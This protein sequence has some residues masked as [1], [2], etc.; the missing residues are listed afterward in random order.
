MRNGHAADVLIVSLGSTEGLRRAD[1]E[2]RDSLRRAGASVAL[3]RTHAPARLPTLM[4]TDLA[5]ARA[6]RAS[7]VR[8]LAQLAHS[9]PRAV[10]YSSTTAALLWPRAG[11]IRFDAPSAGNRPAT[12]ARSGPGGGGAAGR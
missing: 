6:A 8:T 12:G 2:L 1:E 10:L 5:W 3:A 11:A 7:A 4:L 9:P